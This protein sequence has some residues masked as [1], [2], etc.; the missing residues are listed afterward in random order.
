MSLFKF[1]SCCLPSRQSKRNHVLDSPVVVSPPKIQDVF[2]LNMPDLV[3]REILK[4]LDFL[5][6]KKLR[7]TSYSLRKFI[8]YVKIDSGLKDF[9]IEMTENTIF[10]SAT[11]HM[12][13]CPST[14][15]ISTAYIENEDGKCEVKTGGCRCLR[16]I[17]ING[18]FVDVY[19]EDFLTPML[20]NQNSLLTTLRLG[21]LPKFVEGEKILMKISK[22]LFE[23]VFDCLIKV[24]ESRDRILQIEDLEVYVLGQDQLMVL[25]RHIDLK[26]LKRLE[27]CRLVEN[28]PENNA[29]FM[30]DLSLLECAENLIELRVINFTISSPLRSIAHVPKLSVDMHTI[31]CDDVLKYHETLLTTKFRSKSSVWYQQFPDKRRF[32]N[33]RGLSERRFY[34]WV[35]ERIELCHYPDS[36]LMFWKAI[37]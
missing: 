4:N 13:G 33:T 6:I 22:S 32:K 37:Y 19:F 21:R 29:E 28:D 26:S 9:K 14:E 36:K 35:S 24:L 20:K 31:H 27:V 12:K 2:L 30:L 11:V 7:K 23:K 16:N 5:T 25:L 18:Y 17:I 8:D 1:F 34:Y 15:Y 10:G 3:M